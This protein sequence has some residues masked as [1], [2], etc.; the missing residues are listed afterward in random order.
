MELVRAAGIGPGMRVLDVAAGDGNAAA[1][2]YN[3]DAIVLSAEEQTAD[4]LA[5]TRRMDASGRAAG[6]QLQKLPAHRTL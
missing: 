5:A 1:L 4:A 3:P 6:G 2:P